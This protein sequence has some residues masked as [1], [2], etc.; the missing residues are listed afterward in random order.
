MCAHYFSVSE[1]K[2]FVYRTFSAVYEKKNEQTMINFMKTSSTFF[3]VAVTTSTIESC[4]CLD[5]ASEEV[6]I[7]FQEQIHFIIVYLYKESENVPLTQS[8]QT[9]HSQIDVL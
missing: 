2:I 4:V 9:T 6:G 5:V 3:L 8:A 1:P 7:Q